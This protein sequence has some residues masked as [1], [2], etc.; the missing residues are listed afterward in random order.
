MCIRDS[1]R[2]SFEYSSSFN[3]KANGEAESRVKK[4]KRAITHAVLNG[5]DPKEAILC[6]NATQRADATGSTSNLF[7]RRNTRPGMIS[8]TQ[9]CRILGQRNNMEVPSHSYSLIN[10][11]TGKELLCSEWMLCQ[12]DVMMVG[13]K[14]TTGNPGAGQWGLRSDVDRPVHK[15]RKETIHIRMLPAMTQE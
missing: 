5:N 11:I 10:L 6:M 15:K 3:P 14:V 2:V 1:Y 4:A 9:G 7:F 13:S 12:I 8:I